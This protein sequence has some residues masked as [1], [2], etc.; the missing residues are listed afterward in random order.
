MAVILNP[1]LNWR[2]GAREAMEFYRSV[3]GGELNLMTFAEG[4]MQV[5][6]SESELIMHGQLETPDG[7]TLMGA[8]T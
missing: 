5:D 4:G 7:F 6:P 1:Y 8:D 2:S 3:F